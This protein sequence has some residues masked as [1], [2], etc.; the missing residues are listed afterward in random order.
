MVI[1]H[2]GGGRSLSHSQESLEAFAGGD[3]HP[4]TGVPPH[5]PVSTIIANVGIIRSCDSMLE[6]ARLSFST[7]G[8][9]SINMTI[10]L[11]EELTSLGVSVET[12]H[13]LPGPS[14]KGEGEQELEEEC[15]APQWV[16]RMKAGS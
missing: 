15:R 1:K 4:S 7:Q 3:L 9:S 13:L 8:V 16:A 11:S 6:K 14:N 2:F 5:S 12:S 10:K